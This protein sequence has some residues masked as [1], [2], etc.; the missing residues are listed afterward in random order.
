M[1]LE[2]ASKFATVTYMTATPIESKYLF[3]EFKHLP[4]VEI[5]WP[6][7]KKIRVISQPTNKPLKSICKEID[8][9]LSDRMFGNLHIFLN[10]VDS[11]IEAIKQSGLTHE[12]VKIV[13]SE[14]KNPGNGKKA[15]QKKLADELGEDFKIEKPLDPVKKVNFYTSTC[16]EG[17]DIYDPDGRTYIISDGNKRHTQLDIS[18]LL[19]QICGRIRDSIYKEI[20]HIYSYTHTRY[21][22]YISVEEYEAKVLLD[23]ENAKMMVDE[24]NRL[25]E[26]SR[27]RT[28]KAFSEN[29]CNENY[30]SIADN[31]LHLDKNLLNLD[32]VNFKIAN[33][34]YSNRIA[35]IEELKKNDIEFENNPYDYHKSAD[36]LKANRKAKMPFRETF[37]DYV[38]LQANKSGFGILNEEI[39]LINAEKPLVGEAY[40]KLGVERVRKLNYHV[41]NIKTEIV[42]RSNVPEPKKVK[43][44][45][46]EKLGH[47][48]NEDKVIKETIQSIYNDLGIKKTAKS[49]SLN[50]YFEIKDCMKGGDRCKVIIKEKII[51]GVSD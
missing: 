14:N 49:T 47:G 11:I 20:T 18:T 51:Y 34:T 38:K 5:V 26:E 3:R 45:I 35:Y 50:D 6:N 1:I 21:K 29:Y 30:F 42:R 16:F 7:V 15:N 48:I 32:V 41:G 24:L 44:L 28:V 17:C 2:E 37:E 12:Q 13:C 19:I 39:N 10:S 8:M 4:V 40:H 46:I 43:E 9:V 27:L 25:S 22:G 23:Y 33:G 36:A 31:K